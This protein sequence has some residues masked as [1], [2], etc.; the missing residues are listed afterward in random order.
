M[1]SQ[2]QNNFFALNFAS[3]DRKYFNSGNF[4]ICSIVCM[5]YDTDNALKIFLYIH[6]QLHYQ[7][8]SLD[9]WIALLTITTSGVMERRET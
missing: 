2:K 9:S 5:Y 6:I 4:A 1:F 3:K 7:Q 8:M